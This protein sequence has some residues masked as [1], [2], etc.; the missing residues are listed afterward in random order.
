M[1]VTRPSCGG[2]RPSCFTS[3]LLTQVTAQGHTTG[4]CDH[5]AT[6][7][8]PSS[9]S[10]SMAASF[11]CRATSTR[12][13]LRS[14]SRSACASAVSAC[15]MID[16]YFSPCGKCRTYCNK[17]RSVSEGNHLRIM[18]RDIAGRVIYRA[19]ASGQQARLQ[20]V[21]KTCPLCK[22]VVAIRAI[23]RALFEALDLTLK[24]DSLE[25]SNLSN[26]STYDRVCSKSQP[27][28]NSFG[29]QQLKTGMVIPLTA[30]ARA[31]AFTL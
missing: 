13:R 1:T 28:W 26:R 30:I 8:V 12:S 7:A 10:A 31:S 18:C 11:S 25:E 20:V 6:S 17:D 3:L 5:A 24:F 21:S 14:A 15:F 4:A 27:S 9:D 16:T 23:R 2:I 29:Q 22:C 19:D